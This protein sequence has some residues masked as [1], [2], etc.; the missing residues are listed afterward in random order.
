MYHVFRNIQVHRLQTFFFHK[1]I[2]RQR[3][4]SPSGQRKKPEEIKHSEKN[5]EKID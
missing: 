2:E 4:D 3:R 1:V 5:L